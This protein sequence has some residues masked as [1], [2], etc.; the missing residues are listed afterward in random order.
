MNSD[1]TIELI[2]KTPIKLRLRYK[3]IY[4]L[5]QRNPKAAER[6]FKATGKETMNEI[7]MLTVVYTAFLCG[8]AVSNLSFEEFI[9][10]FPQNRSVLIETYMKLVYPKN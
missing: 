6:Y 1:I 5:E 8:T 4:E 2:D 9:E 7:D 3:D 10:K